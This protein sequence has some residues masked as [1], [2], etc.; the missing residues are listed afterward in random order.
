MATSRLPSRWISLGTILVLAIAA[1]IVFVQYRSSEAY[2]GMPAAQR[3]YWSWITS[4]NQ[5]EPTT[6]TH[7]IDLLSDHPDLRSLYL[8]LADACA[9]AEWPATCQAALYAV[10]PQDP[11]AYLYR[12][13]AL[14]Q[15]EED[16][17]SDSTSA[18]VSIRWHRMA[19]SPHL[20]P[21]LARLLV[22]RAR[23]EGDSP[24]LSE[25]EVLWRGQLAA[26]SSLSGAA[27]G[28]G[29]AAIW[30]GR[31]QD[32]ERL[33]LHTADVRPENPEAYRE[34]GRIYYVTGRPDR[35]D[36]VLQAGI[37]AAAAQYDMENELIL[38]GNLGWGIMQRDGNLERAEALFQSAL[39]Q[40][41]QLGDRETEGFNLYRLA[42]V[43][44]KQDRYRDA[45]AMLDDAEAVCEAH[46][47]RQ[48]P[49][50]LALRGMVLDQLF[51]FSDAEHV[52]SKAQARAAEQQD[53][54]T[55]LQ[56]SAL[57][58]QVRFRMGRYSDAREIAL[59]T[60]QLAQQYQQVNTA[61]AARV[62][63]GDALRAGGDFEG[64]L[65]AYEA[66]LEE[67]EQI[68][69]GTR[70]REVYHRL[71]LTSMNMQDADAAR[72]YFDAMLGLAEEHGNALET[73]RVYGSLGR[74]YH[75]YR[76]YDE[77]LR[78]Y[79]LALSSLGSQTE[80]DTWGSLLLLKSWTLLYESRYD[81]A[82]ALLDQAEKLVGE[83]PLA[84]YRVEV[85]R[86]NV[87][88]DQE[89]YTEALAHF[90]AAS[91]LHREVQ[92]P[93]M[94]WHVL[95][96]QALAYWQLQ[97]LE[98]AERAFRSSIQIIEQ[99]RDNL[100][101][102]EN[103]SVFVQDKVLV[104]KNFASF[105]EQ[106]NRNEEAFHYTERA[107]SRSLVDLLYTTQ[108]E[109]A[110]SNEDL[111][112][113]AIENNRRLRALT[114]EVGPGMYDLAVV[115]AD[116]SHLRTAHL[117]QEQKQVEMLQASLKFN[118]EDAL[119]TFNPL[120]AADAQAILAPGEAMVVFNLRKQLEGVQDASVAY[121]VLEDSIA[122]VPLELDSESLTEVVRFFRDRISK[123]NTGPGTGWEPAARR[124][125][126]DLIAP[127][128]AV[129]PSSVQH[130]HLVPEGVLHYLPFGA[131]LARDG[132]FLVERYSLSVSPSA[133]ILKLCRERNPRRWST[134][135]LLADPDGRLPGSRQE[136]FDIAAKS[137][138][139]RFVFAGS[140]ATQQ[141][142]E[143]QAR[144]YDILHFAT[145]G[146]F[147]RR[148]PWR[149][150]LELAGDE[151]TV[152]EIGK[153]NLDES[154]L[155]TLSACETGLSGGLVSDIPR[156]DEWVGLNQA[157]LAAGAP[158]VM[159]S[160]WPIDDKVS[161]T[162][163][164]DFYERLGPKGKAQA[165][166]EVQRSFLRSAQTRHP[167]YWAAFSVIGDPL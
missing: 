115:D 55:Q 57:L 145:H 85:A 125:Y 35:F 73:A 58:A 156:G 157:F 47:P 26:D 95:H 161:S 29:Y 15:L 107:R 77:A 134:I 147:V 49:A 159:A 94:H 37:E 137:P 133:S 82:W 9:E 81:E 143:D 74:T 13:A 86:G 92:W 150:H 98:A 141:V 20:D 151:L 46:A 127:V 1:G 119:Y 96:G 22:D 101:S 93:M 38:R 144:N 63:L 51:R 166:A 154:Y 61:I 90:N 4:L 84:R 155:V 42:E 111:I 139:R 108:Q 52:L 103:R 2:P 105:L 62:V 43:R 16:T 21:T 110:Y 50:V 79:D 120:D 33:L 25:M 40:S 12:E 76:N 99:L 83:G 91:E 71:G 17:R 65:A 142:L 68:R 19:A 23:S 10:R 135:L 116:S 67:A 130:L 59:N 163:M 88:L 60:L 128:Q 126:Q 165:L 53:V 136:A 14:A 31:W 146:N 45:L 124:L 18:A 72:R 123:S 5:D 44:M 106:Q 24:W 11:T 129:L 114:E 112:D 34:L 30:Q 27:F 153:L 89:R 7:G 132:R 102:A 69:S 32:A 104:Y 160:L 6:L 122:V 138:Y 70:M 28:L 148:A 41:R 164:V 109:R 140:R 75:Q 121:V 8:K 66:S 56:A 39:D 97:Q 167:F 64:A 100:S 118:R 3:A 158:T 80:A 162:F 131:L 78:Y 152:A 117:R 87:R 54:G 113:L 36:A 48:V 149:S